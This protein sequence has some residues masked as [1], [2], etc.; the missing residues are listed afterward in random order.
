MAM[1]EAQ[2][3][4]LQAYA[5]GELSRREARAVADWI[6]NDAEARALLAEL[7]HTRSALDLYAADLK[8]PEAR[9]FFWSKIEREIRRLEPPATR[10][11]DPRWWADWRKLL[12][13]AAALA[14]LVAAVRFLPPREAVPAPESAE[15]RFSLNDSEAF[16]YRD[17]ANGTTLVWLSYPAENEFAKSDYEDTLD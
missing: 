3:L 14:A 11:P 12:V 15:S 17:Y 13:P 16:T 4:K 7:R 1:N 5:D 10:R 9:D 2:Q 8:L 6:A